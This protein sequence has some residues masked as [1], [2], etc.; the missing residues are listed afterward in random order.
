MSAVKLKKNKEEINKVTH[1]V[2]P[3]FSEAE[4]SKK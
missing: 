2:F 1:E 3:R 4:E